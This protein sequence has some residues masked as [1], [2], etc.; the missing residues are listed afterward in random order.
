MGVSGSYL[1]VWVGEHRSF[2]PGGEFPLAFVD[3]AVVSAAQ[4]DEVARPLIVTPHHP[5]SEG[6]LPLRSNLPAIRFRLEVAA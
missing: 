2:G 4:Q 3:H 1:A 5:G 6:L